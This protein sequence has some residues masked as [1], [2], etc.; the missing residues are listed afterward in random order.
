MLR[1]S[2]RFLKEL[3]EIEIQFSSSI[4]EENCILKKLCLKKVVW[5]PISHHMEAYSCDNLLHA[6]ISCMFI[7]VCKG[8]CAKARRSSDWGLTVGDSV[9]YSAVSGLLKLS[10][11]APETPLKCIQL[12]GSGLTDKFSAILQG[13]SDNVFWDFQKLVLIW[14][15]SNLLLTLI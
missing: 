1:K 11:T 10:E 8:F 7:R 13:K 5:V 15:V 14:P 9:F 4:R 6:I 2:W 12:H 3:L